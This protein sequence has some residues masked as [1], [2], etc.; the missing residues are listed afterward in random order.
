MLARTE[1]AYYFKFMKDILRSISFY[2]FSIEQMARVTIIIVVLTRGLLPAI[3]VI[4]DKVYNFL[5]V[6]KNN[7]TRMLRMTD[8]KPLREHP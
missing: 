2:W 1:Y 6:K 5:H 8:N 4:R 3:P 7:L